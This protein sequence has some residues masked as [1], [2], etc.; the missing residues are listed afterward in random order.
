[1]RRERRG[2]SRGDEAMERGKEDKEVRSMER[3]G[4]KGGEECV[5]ISLP[6]HPFS[7][8]IWLPQVYSIAV[9]KLRKTSRASK[10]HGFE[11]AIQNTLYNEVNSDLTN[12]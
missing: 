6:L 9:V 5:V 11:F 10:W 1:M 7:N 8:R 3:R 4:R 2:K 12:T